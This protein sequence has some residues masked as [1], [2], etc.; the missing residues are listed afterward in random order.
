MRRELTQDYPEEPIVRVPLQEQNE[1][2]EM[3]VRVQRRLI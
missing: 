2:K 1:W 3:S